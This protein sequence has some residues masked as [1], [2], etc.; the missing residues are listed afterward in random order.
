[1]FAQ[2]YRMKRR[3]ALGLISAATALA[4]IQPRFDKQTLTV[5]DSKLKQSACRWCYNSLSLDQLCQAA[6]KIEIESIELVGPD[7]WPILA[8]HGL[9]C[10]VGMSQPDGFGITKGFNNRT[11][12]DTLIKWYTDLIPVAAKAGIRQVIAFSGNRNGISDQHGLANCATGLRKL[13]PI[14]EKHKVTITME[15]LNSK[16]DHADYQCDHTDWGVALCQTVD[17]EYFKLLYDIYHMQIMEGDVIRTIQNAAPY[18]SHY[19]TGGVPGRHEI[20]DTQELNYRAIMA[21]IAATGYQG[22][23]GQEF[24]PTRSNPIDSLREGVTICR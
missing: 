9:N 12:H 19:H 4:L 1:M 18:I 10:A 21:A 6:G 22:Y 17:S 2:T 3:D 14:A 7:E 8:Q 20:N 13:I 24:I 5:P 16:I 11:N 15:L 23:I